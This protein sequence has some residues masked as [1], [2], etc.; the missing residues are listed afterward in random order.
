MKT[1]ATK[2]TETEAHEM[3][4]WLGFTSAGS[5]DYQ[6]MATGRKLH[7]SPAMNGCE[8]V[9]DYQTTFEKSKVA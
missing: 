3:L 4:V 9:R 2:M 5:G 7:I 6:D 8:L 1:L